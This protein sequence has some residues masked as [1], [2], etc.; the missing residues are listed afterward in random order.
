MIRLLPRVLF[1]GA[2]LLVPVLA[3]APSPV[4]AQSLLSASGLGVP[5]EAPDGR[6]RM[7]GNVGVALSGSALLPND[8]ASAGWALLPGITVSGQAGGEEFPD[9]GTAYQSR[10][11]F[12][13]VVYPYGEQVFSLAVSGVFSQ[14]WDVEVDRTLDFAGDPVRAVDRFEGRGGVAAARLGVARRLFEDRVSVGVSAGTHLGSVERRFSRELDVE[15]VGPEVEPFEQEG[16]WRSSGLT[17]AAGAHWDV[18]PLIRVGGSVTWSEDLRLT[19]AAATD[20]AGQQVPLPLE[21][22]GGVFATLTPG[23]GLA[24]SVYRADF[25]DAA[26]AL[27]DA[28]APGVVWQWGGGLEW[29]GATLLGRR[30]PMGVGYRSRDLPFSFL[31]EAAQETALSGGV[32]IHLADAEDTPLA[33]LHVGFETGTR[34]AGALS[35]EFWRTTFT[36][37]LSGR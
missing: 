4:A 36:L 1:P 37:R 5:V 2:A 34:T 3:V 20:G 7:L 33:R 13:G 22:R 21:L 25:S 19:P 29:S 23:L 32:G 24:A 18:T 16:V 15:D 14:E 9:G 31:G 11:P 30:F 12:L 17:A 6:S 10:F 8:P 26:A 35:E 27:G 28:S